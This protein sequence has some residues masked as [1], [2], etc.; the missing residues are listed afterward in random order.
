MF[1]GGI[2][3]QFLMLYLGGVVACG[4]LLLLGKYLG[5][6]R[7][8]TIFMKSLAYVCCSIDYILNYSYF[9]CDLL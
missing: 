2:A 1:C 8:L 6:T 7:L 9:E 5:K 4:L 3:E